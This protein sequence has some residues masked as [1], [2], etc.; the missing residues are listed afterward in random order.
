MDELASHSTLAHITKVTIESRHKYLTVGGKE[1]GRY[2]CGLGVIH[3]GIPHDGTCP[4][5]GGAHGGGQYPRPNH[6]GGVLE[7]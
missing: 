5:A 1:E 2:G 7:L 6:G 4:P 3:R